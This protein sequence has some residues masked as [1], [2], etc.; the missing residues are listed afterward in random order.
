MVIVSRKLQR[1]HNSILIHTKF[2]SRLSI[3]TEEITDATDVT[4][5]QSLEKGD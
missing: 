5:M 3:G 4:G 1:L 2:D